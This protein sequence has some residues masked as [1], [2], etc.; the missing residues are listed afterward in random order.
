MW[1][2]RCDK[3][4]KIIEDSGFVLIKTQYE[5]FNRCAEELSKNI[6][7][8]HKNQICLNC[9]EKYFKLEDDK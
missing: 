1:C 3:C 9:Y 5:S 4:G 8:N 6:R 7:C 2:L